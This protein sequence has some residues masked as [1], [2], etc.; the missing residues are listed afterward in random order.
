MIGNPMSVD[1][2]F[3]IDTKRKILE[4]FMLFMVLA[5]TRLSIIITGISNTMSIGSITII[6]GIP[7]S[8]KAGD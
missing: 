2:R 4:N 5:I 3:D 8:A 7:T 6:I 1:S